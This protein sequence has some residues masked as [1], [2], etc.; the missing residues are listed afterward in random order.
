[1]DEH[2]VHIE[3]H[4]VRELDLVLIIVHDDI[5]PLT[6]RSVRDM[7]D[8][9][10]EDTGASFIVLPE[11]VV[12]DFRSMNLSE[13]ISLRDALDECI[14]EIAQRDIVGDA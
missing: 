4:K 12:R 6:M 2:P 9:A 11:S 3:C 14:T 13:M 10:S 1:M 7:V 8:D 5:D